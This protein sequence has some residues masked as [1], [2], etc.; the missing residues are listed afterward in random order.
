MASFFASAVH[1]Q[2]KSVV[3]QIPIHG[4]T[5][6]QAEERLLNVP[7]K[8]RECLANQSQDVSSW[9]SLSV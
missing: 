8:E 9:T 2:D 6:G 1:T 3:C 7:S 5:D 4:E